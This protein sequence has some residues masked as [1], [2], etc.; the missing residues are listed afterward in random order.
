MVL[1]QI[2]FKAYYI[3]FHKPLNACICCVIYSGYF[4]NRRKRETINYTFFT[5]KPHIHTSI[6]PTIPEL[7]IH[8][9]LV[10]IVIKNGV[11][12]VLLDL[13]AAFNT[14]DHKIMLSRLK[15]Y[16]RI[17]GNAL[18]W[19]K[20]YMENR[21]Q[22]VL[23]KG[24]KSEPVNLTTGVPQGSVLGP[25]LLFIYMLP[26]YQI[27]RKHGILFHGYADDTQLYILFR[28]GD[29][30]SLAD[31]IHRLEM[32]IQEIRIWMTANKLKLND[33]KTDFMVIVSAYY[34]QLITSLEIAIKVGNTN[35]HPTMS[36]KNL[37]VTLDTNMTMQ[38]FRQGGGGSGPSHSAPQGGISPPC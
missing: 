27:M 16:C 9:W 12:L 32:C 18:K 20:S 34:Q 4:K 29:A 19:F 36:V 35:I 22:T 13:S 24:S 37:G 15:F 11:L 10:L 8:D 26:L 30:V 21:T 7:Y 31:A 25:L 3:L 5:I 14:I 23:V 1:S 6:H 38:G 17:T 2:N 28:P 33:G